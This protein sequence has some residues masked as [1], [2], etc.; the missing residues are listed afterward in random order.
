MTR[1]DGMVDEGVSRRRVLAGG[2]GAAAALGVSRSRLLGA[3]EQTLRSVSGSA[4]GTEPS[5]VENV[6]L[7]DGLVAPIGLGLSDVVFGW[8]VP[9]A[10]RGARQR[11]YRIAVTHTDVTGRVPGKRV[12]DSGRV[13]SAAD[14]F[15]PYGGRPLKPDSVYTCRV[16]TWDGPGELTSGSASGTFETGLDDRHWRANWIRRPASSDLE[17]D[18]YTYARKQA[19]LAASPI[20][21]ARAYVS[22]DQQYEMW[23]N[24]V[25]VGKGQ[26]Y[27]YPN[28]RYYETLDLTAVL[29]AG[30]ANAFG[31]LYSWDGATKGHPAGAPGVIAQV[32]VLHQDGT[33]ETIVTD[34]SWRV[35]KGAWLA[36][37]QRDL[38]GDFVDYT[39]NIDGR[40]VPIGWDTPGFDDRAWQPATVVAAAGAKP[41]THLVSVRTRIVE[42]PVRAV[43]LT[44]LASGAV[45]ADFGKVYA[46]V[47][48]VRFRHGTPGR[49]VNMHAGYLLDEPVKGEPFVGA[50]GHV[51]VTRGTQHTDMSY[52]YVQRGGAEQ[53]H[54]FDYL[55]FRYFQI[56]DPGENLAADDV[57]AYT[58]HAAVPDEHAATFSSSN[59][60]IDAIFELGRHSALFTAQEQFIDTPTREKGPWLWDGFN[61]SKTAMA[62]FGEQNL[63]RKSL[64]EFAASQGRYWPNGAINKI[65]PTGLGALDINEFTEIYPEWVWQYW[66]HTGDRT[67]LEMVYPVLLNLSDYVR[68][69]VDPRTGLVTKLPA[70]NVYYPFPTV[71][72]MNVLGADVFR[73][74]ADVAAALGRPA[75]DV[76]R[77]RARQ[78]ALTDAINAHLTRPDGTYVD[79]LSI[80]RHQ[81]PE[82]SQDTNACA[83]VYGV[84]PA[85][86]QASVAAYVARFGMGSPPRTATEVLDALA[87]G[88]RVADMVRI[89][90]DH[91]HDGWANILARGGTFTWEVWQPSDVIGDSMSHGWGSNVL[92]TI[93]RVLLGVTPTGAGYSTFTVSPPAVG[94]TRASGTVPTPHGPIAVAWQRSAA[95]GARFTI[96]LT[97]PRNTVATLTLPGLA[98]TD[99]GA[100]RHRLERTLRS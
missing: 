65:Y 93:Q 56:D 67:L 6:V 15:V 75:D 85:N 86:R 31:L 34:G 9:G 40:A 96:D 43:S 50:P 59:P 63:T 83:L 4:A 33:I 49:V 89:L 38:E 53:F 29:R 88:G 42:E 95:P 37:T 1:F 23:V 70:T 48:T 24:G 30:G 2:L 12:W 80:G 54:P 17:P 26:A 71:T 97:V 77:Q 91:A 82:A 7:V 46:A 36:G 79:G 84:V 19:L 32:S 45:V 76:E 92:V 62:A 27:C 20:V 98:A 73:R 10:S 35:R 25:R 55:G 8:R 28:A 94:P 16:Q 41:W 47:P 3:A 58:R 61:E 100:G 51:S 52:S 22:G 21:R 81:I 13:R 74:V 64:L 18:E 57:V 5:A 60:T 68:R 11:A 99:F 69:A 39:E 66:M 87:L 14:A 90:G 44:R 72:R 78:L